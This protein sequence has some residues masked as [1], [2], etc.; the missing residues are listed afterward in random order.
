MTPNANASLAPAP[1]RARTHTHTAKHVYIKILYAFHSFMDFR[2]TLIQQYADTEVH[3]EMLF[4]CG[5]SNS[6]STSD[7]HVLYSVNLRAVMGTVNTEHPLYT[8]QK[9]MDLQLYSATVYSGN[10]LET[11]P[12]DSD[13]F[14]EDS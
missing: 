12:V 9:H 7:Q 5:N 4:T 10:G 3:I 14:N 6:R 11:M 1:A 2:Y 8:L 13:I